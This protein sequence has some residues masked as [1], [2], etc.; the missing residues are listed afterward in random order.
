MTGEES[1]NFFMAILYPADNLKILAYNRVLK[2]LGELSD[3]EFLEKI[4]ESFDVQPIERDDTMV[5]AKH[6]FS[7]LI[8]E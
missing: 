4:R 6:Q 8:K 2:S 1:F 7:L 5:K 3:E